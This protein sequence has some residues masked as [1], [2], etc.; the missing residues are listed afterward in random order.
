[1]R[2]L[3]VTN[4]FPPKLGGIQSYLWELWRRLPPDEVAVLTTR[5]PDAA[6]F[7]AAAPIRIERTAES[8]LLPT[9]SLRRRIDQLAAEVGADAVVL[10][11]AL[12]VG[13]LGPRLARPYGLVLHGAEITVPGRSP[14][15]GA[16]LGRLL[17]GAAGIVAAGGYPAAEAERAAGRPLPTTIVPPGVDTETFVPLDDDGRAKARRSFGLP[18][19]GRLIVSLSRL[20]PRK[21]MDVLIRAA[22]QLAPTRPDLTVAIGGDG[23]DRVRLERLVEQTGAPVRLLGRVPGETMPSLY[24]SADLFAMLCRDRWGGLEQEGFGI[25]FLEAA[26]AGVPSVAGLS[27]GSAEAVVDGETGLVVSRP[28][29]VDAA[30]EA[31]ARL[32]DDPDRARAMGAAARQR[33]ESAFSYDR[34]AVDLRAALTALADGRMPP[35]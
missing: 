2:T 30:A 32:V 1:V 10:D 23:R 9:P 18:E 22:A 33:A 6:A 17:R 34:L 28:A 21:G 4:D 16:L 8:V 13:L 12:P 5:H 35:C 24:A 26:A 19:D 25:V 20:V 11:P 14:G 3:L 7:D 31:L 15:T 29:D 27:G